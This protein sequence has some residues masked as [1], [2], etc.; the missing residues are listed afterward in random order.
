M[1]NLS[2][3]LY[4]LSPVSSQFPVSCENGDPGSP[5]S[6]VNVDPGSPFSQVNVDPGPYIPRNIDCFLWSMRTIGQVLYRQAEIWLWNTCGKVVQWRKHRVPI[7]PMG[8]SIYR[9]KG[10]QGPH[11]HGVPKNI[12][13]PV[14]DVYGTR[15][16]NNFS[17][18]P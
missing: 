12:M 8:S 5:F 16:S 2:C 15:P 6:Q 4:E 1:G 9:E 18:R 11:C 3:H 7:F 10:T 17:P 14:C 13:T